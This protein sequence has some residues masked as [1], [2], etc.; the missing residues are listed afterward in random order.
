MELI[1]Q[2]SPMLRTVQLSGIL[3]IIEGRSRRAAFVHSSEARLLDGIAHH[4]D[5]PPGV[6]VAA[7]RASPAITRRW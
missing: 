1:H 2:L 6:M 7:P 5:H 4:A 3:E